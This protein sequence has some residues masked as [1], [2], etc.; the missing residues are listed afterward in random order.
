MQVKRNLLSWFDSC[1][2]K[3]VYIFDTLQ[4]HTV[5]YIKWMLL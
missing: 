1:A 3:R 5:E 2:Q 4:V